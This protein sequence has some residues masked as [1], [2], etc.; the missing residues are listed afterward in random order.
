M[1]CPG[2]HV[3]N[4]MGEAQ[5]LPAP[6]AF[7]PLAGEGLLGTKELL[8]SAVRGTAL[9]SLDCGGATEG[10]DGDGLA[11]TRAG[12]ETEAGD[13]ETE[14]AGTG[15]GVAREAFTGDC[16][17]ARERD[18]VGMPRSTTGGP[19]TFVDTVF[20]VPGAATV[21]VAL[22]GLDCQAHWGS[23]A[24]GTATEA[25]ASVAAVDGDGEAVEITVVVVSGMYMAGDGCLLHVVAMGV[26]RRAV[27]GSS[28]YGFAAYCFVTAGQ[29]D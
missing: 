6:P 16:T 7:S 11:S 8:Q 3:R 22:A 28:T 2:A 15:A 25:M 5:R 26:V 27:I 23:V 4:T 14:V 18:G 21:E 10:V 12:M 9:R 17:R 19:I 1:P 29:H 13:I 20:G 24:E